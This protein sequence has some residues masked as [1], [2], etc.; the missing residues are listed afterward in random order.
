[1][2]VPLLPG[3][4]NKPASTTANGANPQRNSGGTILDGGSTTASS[5]VTNSLAH[6]RTFNDRGN[7]PRENSGSAL[8]HAAKANSAGSRV[9]AYHADGKY[10]IRRVS[11]TL[12]GVSNDV[13]VS[14][15]SNHPRRSI[16]WRGN[17]FGANLL[18]GHRAG[19]WRP[20]GI[21]KDHLGTPQRTNWSSARV[22]A[23]ENYA[24]VNGSLSATADHAAQP[25]RAIPGELVYLENHV[26]WSDNYIDYKARS[27]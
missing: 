8:Q 13:M 11:D 26:T 18:A 21:G 10:V 1:M 4:G 23:D 5:A 6:G 27:G 24:G 22:S 19:E 17:Q 7:G 16:H 20:L 25:S 14:G 12:T 9:F 3:G 2:A 15:G